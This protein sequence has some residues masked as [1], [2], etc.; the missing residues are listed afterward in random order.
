[1]SKTKLVIYWSWKDLR[2]VDNP[3]LTSSL[4]F[5]KEHKIQFLP[6]FILDDG[7]VQKDKYNI[8]YPRRKML[9]K[10]LAKFAKQFKRFE[11]LIG[12]PQ[13]V[14]QDLEKK[15]ELYLFTNN[16]LEPYARK[17]HKNIQQALDNRFFLFKDQLSVDFQTRSG[18]GN[19]YSVFSPFRK[20][21]WEEFISAKALD[22]ADLDKAD[23]LSDKL[24]TD[25]E[26]LDI[27]NN[28]ETAIFKRIDQEWVL[29]YAEGSHIL[30]LDKLFER[31]NLDH[32]ESSEKEVL[33]SFSGFLDRIKNY[34]TSR[35][36]MNLAVSEESTSKVSTALSFGLVSARTL[37]NQILEKFDADEKGVFSYI[38]EL[39]W[40]E[41]YRYILYHNPYVM[42]LEYQEKFQNKVKW[43]SEE[44]ALDRFK[45]WIKGETGY[46]IVD[47]GM[48][49]I[50]K[51]GYMHNRTRMIV[52]SVL[53]KNLGV[54]WRWGQ[55]YFRSMLTDLDEAS[56]NG[57]WQWAAS[58]GAD[59]KP[60]RIF[61]PYLQEDK[62]DP[63]GAYRNKWLDSSFE[64][65]QKTGKYNYL[66]PIVEHK[67]ARAEA[68][69]RYGL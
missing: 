23:F 24:Q 36:D 15:Y 11:I 26:T 57:G 13:E 38:S 31:P 67:E 6:I 21:V 37:K 10:V 20:A 61:N 12:E 62:Y 45:S 41:F 52:G 51:T 14:F 68:L 33:N 43:A 49:E 64:F 47:A 54:D 34:K 35:D 1:M 42:N 29:K 59:P 69:E 2:L 60:I 48:H 25:V 50:S 3:A 9:S 30:T 22:K 58:V 16:D 44:I 46:A 28:P 63:K 7:W 27:S 65:D 55:D 66:K 32:V 4:N 8:G 5:S 56:N 19:I 40:R 39:I 53:T 18:A 17:R